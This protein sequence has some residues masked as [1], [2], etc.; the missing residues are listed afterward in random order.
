MQQEMEAWEEKGRGISTGTR[1]GIRYPGGVLVRALQSWRGQ[2]HR[3][4]LPIL[5]PCQHPAHSPLSMSDQRFLPL[6]ELLSWKR[7][8]NAAFQE[9]DWQR[10]TDAYSSGIE[11][12][13]ESGELDE[14][15]DLSES[16]AAAA[17]AALYSNRAACCLKLG[18]YEQARSRG[19]RASAPALHQPPT[20]ARRPRQQQQQQQQQGSG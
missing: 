16:P 17:L 13:L 18:R 9:G 8:G 19:R 15:A 3:F 2:A 11:V 14:A 20:P 12:A 6:Q 10:A 7:Q 4:Y 5:L 1:Q